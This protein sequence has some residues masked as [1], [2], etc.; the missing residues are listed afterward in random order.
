MP[1][2]S[3]ASALYAARAVLKENS[4]AVRPPERLPFGARPVGGLQANEFHLS[5][6]IDRVTN[7][8]RIADLRPELSFWQQRLTA[9]I[10]EP[11]QLCI[12]LK[13]LIEAIEYVPRYP[14]EERTPMAAS[15]LPTGGGWGSFRLSK[16]SI[17]A[18]GYIWQFYEVTQLTK[19]L[20]DDLHKLAVAKMIEVGLGIYKALAVLPKLRQV[21]S[22]LAQGALT[23]EEIQKYFMVVGILLEAMP[24]FE[25]RE[26]Q[27]KLLV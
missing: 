18:T 11:S 27:T 5:V 26:E 7:A 14:P 3:S 10:A 1:H 6:I 8:Y 16:A 23:E 24:N 2:R 25:N 12:F 21:L 15:H 13:K 22:L 4:I 9:R 19:Q 17:D 20:P